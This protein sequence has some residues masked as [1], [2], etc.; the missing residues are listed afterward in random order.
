MILLI[1]HV[2]YHDWLRS[3]KAVW[4]IE[5]GILGSFIGVDLLGLGFL[6]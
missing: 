2:P 5:Q 3:M 6:P 4:I 1:P